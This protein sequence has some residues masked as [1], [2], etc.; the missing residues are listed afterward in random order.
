LEP[1][2]LVRCSSE[3]IHN[4]LQFGVLKCIMQLTAT[5][6]GDMPIL[7]VWQSHA[8]DSMEDIRARIVRGDKFH[9][10]G[11]PATVVAAVI[12]IDRDPISRYT[13]VSTN[14]SH[15]PTIKLF[16]SR[17]HSMDSPNWWYNIVVK[18]YVN[19]IRYLPKINL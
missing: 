3:Y 2:V 7:Q 17:H 14:P 13:C 4:Q 11:C 10:Y 8:I 15:Y 16:C 19:L 18:E 9:D 12:Y 1:H 6:L 5:Q